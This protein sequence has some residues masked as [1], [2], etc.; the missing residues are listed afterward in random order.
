MRINVAHHAADGQTRFQ[1]KHE[2]GAVDHLCGVSQVIAPGADIPPQASH[3]G[4]L[5]VDDRRCRHRQ[6]GESI[7][8]QPRHRKSP[9]GV[10]TCLG[11]DARQN[12]RAMEFPVVI[13]A[14]RLISF[15]LVLQV[16]VEIVP[17]GDHQPD[18]LYARAGERPACGVEK[19]PVD[20]DVVLGEI[21]REVGP[22]DGIP[23]RAERAVVAP[24][25]TIQSGANPSAAATKRPCRRAG[26]LSSSA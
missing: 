11:N 6:D 7:A 26:R 12:P 14:T 20:C 25:V 23:V 5:S 3:H 22:F 19:P 4:D 2:S 10:C 8:P 21:E 16:R 15:G 9:R 17:D 13:D 24:Q 1:L 18:K